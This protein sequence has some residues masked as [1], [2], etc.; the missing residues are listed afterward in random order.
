VCIAGWKLQR[1][2]LRGDDR[3]RAGV[4]ALEGAGQDVRAAQ[5]LLGHSGEAMTR[6]YVEGKYAKRVKPAR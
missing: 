6:G 5:R 2:R 1:L 3:D 4:D